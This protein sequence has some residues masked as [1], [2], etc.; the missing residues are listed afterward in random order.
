MEM[1]VRGG[2]GDG[3]KEGDEE[4][5]A[6]VVYNDQFDHL[7]QED[8][9]FRNYHENQLDQ[10]EIQSQ[11]GPDSY[12][13]VQAQQISLVLRNLESIFLPQNSDVQYEDHNGA[14]SEG[15]EKFVHVGILLV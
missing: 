13:L 7:K 3:D 4:P 1:V 12:S 14:N 6:E 2:D 11:P 9:L 15:S 8:F 10:V 5:V